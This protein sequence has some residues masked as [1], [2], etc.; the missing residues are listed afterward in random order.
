MTVNHPETFRRLVIAQALEL[1]ARTGIKAN[2]AYTPAA[3][4]KAARDITGQ[5]F[6]ARDYAGAARAIRSTLTTA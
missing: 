5:T 3:M 6:K 4:M 2:T 1:Y